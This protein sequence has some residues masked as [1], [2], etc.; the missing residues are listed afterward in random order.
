[1]QFKVGDT[2]YDGRDEPLMVI[3]SEQDKR[4]IAAMLPGRTKYCQYP[5][6]KFTAEQIDEW[7]GDG[8]PLADY[9]E[10]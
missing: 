5:E 3:L 9:E 4:N 1:M 2:I 7:M 8:Y 6:E 10:P